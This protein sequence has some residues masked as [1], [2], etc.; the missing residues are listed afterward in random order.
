MAHEEKKNQ[1]TETRNDRDDEISTLG[2]YKQ[3]YKA[4]KYDRRYISKI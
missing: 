2:L 1:L 3:Y 4:Y